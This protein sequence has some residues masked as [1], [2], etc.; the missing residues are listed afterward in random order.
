MLL[1]NC[2]LNN[3]PKNLTESV[4]IVRSIGKL[5]PINFPFPAILMFDGLELFQQFVLGCRQWL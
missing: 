3:F 4:L 1:Q 2:F 5:I